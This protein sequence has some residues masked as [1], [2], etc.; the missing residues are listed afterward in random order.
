MASRASQRNF[1]SLSLTLIKGRCLY[2]INAT[3]LIILGNDVLLIGEELRT[4][5]SNPTYGS[6]FLGG[7]Q[8]NALS[9]CVPG[10]TVTVVQPD[11]GTIWYPSNNQTFTFFDAYCITYRGIWCGS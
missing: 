11:A 3:G 10:H 4:F 6:P 5:S 9:P 8:N 7:D 1:T 2:C